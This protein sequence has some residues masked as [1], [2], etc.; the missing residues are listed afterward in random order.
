MQADTF[1]N[2]H[3][4]L[5]HVAL[6]DLAVDSCFLWLCRILANDVKIFHDNKSCI[7]IM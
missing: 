1:M 6:F 3:S 4:T 7:H 5:A 2:A